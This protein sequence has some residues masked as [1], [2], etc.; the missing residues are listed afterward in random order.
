[1][2][3]TTIPTETDGHPEVVADAETERVAEAGA[4]I[5]FP[6]LLRASGLYRWDAGPLWPHLVPPLPA[7]LPPFLWRSEELRLDVDG[8]SPQMTVSGTLRSSLA[9]QTHWVASLTSSGPNQWTG[10]IWYS[11]G[12]LAT[13]Q[14]TVTVKATPTFLHLG[15]TATVTF[16]TPSTVF[17]RQ[18]RFQSASFH[19][20]EFEYDV[21]PDAHPVTAI[22][23][24]DHPNRPPALPCETLTLETVYQRAG[25]AVTKSGGDGQVPVALA[26]ADGAWSNTEMHDAMQVYWS[27]F[28]NIAQWSMWVFWAALSDS[29]QSLGGIM[30]DDIG[31]NHRQGTAIFTDAFIA[32]PPA[33]DLNPAAWVARM[34]F[35]T[36]AHEMGHCFNLAHSW[37]KSLGTSWIPLMDEPEARSFMNYPYNVA[38]GQAAF[39]SDFMFRFSDQELLFMRHAPAGF[40]QMGNAAWFDHH[41]FE[42]PDAARQ[43]SLVLQVR[44]NRAAPSFD[45]LEPVILELKLTNASD[46]PILVDENVLSPENLTV[47][48]AKQG[49]S[50]RQWNPYSSLCHHSKAVALAPGESKY[51]PLQLYAGTNGW[52]ISEPG[53]YTV[54]VA[55]QHG[56][57]TVLSEPLGVR[58]G[59]PGSFAEEDLATDLFSEDVGRTLVFQGTRVLHSAN[60]TLENV[61][62]RLPESRV[63]VHARVALAMPATHPYKVLSVPPG[64]GPMTSVAAVGGVV[65]AHDARPD[66]ARAQLDAA[67][68][69]DPGRAAETLGH[70]VYRRRV[71]RLSA[72]I[73]TAGDPAA[74]AETQGV[75]Q[76]TLAARGALPSVVAEVEQTQQ[77]YSARAELGAGSPKRPRRS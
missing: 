12:L 58:V 47:V 27:R 33:G 68:I 6:I 11:N 46:Q 62:D 21:T 4:A 48:I 7:P 69:A 25:F 2:S 5:P 64:A 53:R 24:C 43:S 38:G 14:T 50:A 9:I 44:A 49:R 55:L 51:A 31:P 10:P 77:A 66:E 3:L 17:T 45:F 36:A 70:I 63:A 52:D 76:E 74:A 28:Q 35:W 40:V 18:Y 34:R 29:G 65:R 72:V 1:M 23:T 15:Q 20:V 75:L 57:A 37:Q 39:F 73:A 8:L 60:A 41:G 22:Q 32:N 56:D 19:P 71:E 59:A 13:P 30:F 61:I 26:G 54:H 67:L 42:R 16:T